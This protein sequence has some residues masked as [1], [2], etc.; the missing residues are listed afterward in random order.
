MAKIGKEFDKKQNKS[1][2]SGGLQRALL[3]RVLLPLIVI[4]LILV[5]GSMGQ[6]R[7]AT[8]A[9]LEASLCGIAKILENHYAMTMPGDYILV[10]EERVSLYK[11]EYELTGDYSILDQ[12]KQA[13]GYEISLFYGNTRILTTLQNESGR[14]ISTGINDHIV[15]LVEEQGGHTQQVQFGQEL[16]YA[17]YYPLYNADGTFVGMLGVAQNEKLLSKNVNQFLLSIWLIVLGG[18]LVIAWMLGQYT[19]QVVGAIQQMKQFL[20]N[21][22]RGELHN[23]LQYQIT[24]RDDEIGEMGKSIVAMQTAVRAL[25]EQDMLT[26]LY[27]RRYGNAKLIRYQRKCSRDGSNY[28]VAVGDIDFFKKV[29][30][31]YGHA[32]G[33]YVLKKVAELLKLHMVGKG[34][35]ARWGGEEFLL[36]F[37]ECDLENAC[38]E[39]ENIRQE[40]EGEE[41]LFE[42]QRIP[43]RMTFGVAQHKAEEEGEETIKR[44]DRLLYYGKN[45]GRNQVVA[46]ELETEGPTK[47][48]E[49]GKSITESR[50]S[51]LAENEV[52]NQMD[53]QNIDAIDLEQFIKNATEE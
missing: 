21:M 5:L 14:A 23:S 12:I 32:A 17:F 47:S 43:V 36:L 1:E 51:A 52:E 16:Y 22:R 42:E 11:G 15:Q 46:E 37:E 29:N 30:D 18:M 33:D 38:K 24:K 35:A 7:K 40:L 13:T 9:Q 10:G 50:K 25:V 4:G 8:Y 45:N 20:Q 53:G 41:L 3:L 48:V 19:K 34:F 39:I 26:G 27:N 49:V 6:Y 2:S 28:S 44:A 31:T